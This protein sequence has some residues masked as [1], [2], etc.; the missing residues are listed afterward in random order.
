MVSNHDEN[1][2]RLL[3]D[4]ACGDVSRNA[5]GV[6]ERLEACDTCRRDLAEQDLLAAQLGDWGEVEREVRAGLAADREPAGSHLVEP[7]VRD[8]LAELTT[9]QTRSTR[10]V[11]A[12]AAAAVLMTAG[13]A[14]WGARDA[15]GPQA[16]G[17]VRLGD[18]LELE[19][20][21][22]DGAFH[23]LAWTAELAPRGCFELTFL[24]AEDGATLPVPPARLVEAS[25]TPTE[26]QLEQLPRAF[27]VRVQ[28]LGPMGE[29][30]G[31]HARLI[32]RA[33]P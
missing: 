11:P 24:A 19:P 21:Y 10:W 1:H 13:A 5:P 17:A 31:A 26:D 23:S 27:R 2:E 15:R 28:V 18:D 29:R 33:G 9:A 32:E 3:L 8:R 20:R 16:S 4:I 30:L 6:R 12:A 14:Y 7:F 25:W 22:V